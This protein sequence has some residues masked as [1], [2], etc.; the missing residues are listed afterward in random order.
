MKKLRLISL[1]ILFIL[2]GII[3]FVASPNLNPLY[4]DGL[5]FWGLVIT[6][7]V[8]VYWL[9]S[10][11][12]KVKGFAG[13]IKDRATGKSSKITKLPKMGAAL[14]VI[15]LA[16]WVILIVVNI[17]SSVVFH[18][19]RYRDQLT[20]PESRQFTSDLQAIDVSQLPVVD[21]NLAYKLADKKLGEKPSLGS[22]VTLGDPTI[23]K[24]D[25]KLVWV[26]P[27]EHSG[28]FKW[29]SNMEGTPGY[30]VVSATDPSDVTYKDS[31]PI[32][33]QPSAYLLDNLTR[34]VR[35]SGGLFTGI[36]DY[37]FELDDSGKPY[38][39]VTT[40]KNELGFNLPE[41][42]GVLVV[43]AA[44]GATK[45]YSIKD[46][47]SWVDR[48][49]PGD[50][51]MTQ[52]K[53]RGKYIHGIFNFSNK[54][55]F[56]P[57]DNYAIVYNNGRCYLF[58]DLTSV[59]S[60]QSATGFMMV[61]MVTKKTYLYQMSG[62]TE[63]AAQKSAEGRL[64]NYKY[65]ASYPLITNVNGEPTYF[66]TLKDEEGLIKQYAF[67]SVKNYMIVGN[68]D[69]LQDAL[70]DYDGKVR[71]APDGNSISTGAKKV[72][73]DGTIARIA[74]EQESG[75]SI[76]KLMLTNK[77]GV[78]FS[79][80]YDLSNELALTRDGDKVR[81]VYSQTDKSLITLTGFTNE[82]IQLK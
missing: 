39:V 11:V 66:M 79:A 46:V 40:Y 73:L 51:I 5:A 1:V 8:V 19:S 53:N 78:I 82:S 26:V 65:T 3:I 54:D 35:F 14:V 9:I 13:E 80:A 81:L 74:M 55:K 31:Y 49:Q 41:A 67:V 44:T 36:T 23:Q 24:V 34:H 21:Y 2:F 27:L 15:A 52:I 12:E 61:D 20:K 58:T 50:Y 71:A 22:Q 62:A 16:P 57:S 45:H 48:V 77:P 6:T 38:W 32:K 63:Y 7:F 42:N 43:D 68:G 69:T 28:F 76:F 75:N 29:L 33:Y 4:D 37:S 10:G 70:D 18:S 72:T 30:I 47:P 60:D 59:G 56:E 64:Q 25:G 17:V